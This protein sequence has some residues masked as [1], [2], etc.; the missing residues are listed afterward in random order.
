MNPSVGQFRRELP[1]LFRAK[2]LWA[3]SI[4]G[5]CC[6]DEVF[7]AYGCRY[8]LERFGVKWVDR[9]EEADLLFVGV[10]LNPKLLKEVARIYQRMSDPKYVIAL[11]AC[12]CTGGLFHRGKSHEKT[13]S[14]GDVVPVDVYVP[15]CPPR[16]EAV[17]DAVIRLQEKIRGSVRAR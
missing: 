6:A 9:P 5:V 4:S 10:P 8:D 15:G 12:S 7:N 17:M 16:P 2:S 14:L 3:Y 13:K 11:G 1:D